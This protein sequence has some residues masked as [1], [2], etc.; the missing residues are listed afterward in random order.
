MQALGGSS[1]NV[2]RDIVH[3]RVHLHSEGAKDHHASKLEQIWH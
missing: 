3:G 2:E 1:N